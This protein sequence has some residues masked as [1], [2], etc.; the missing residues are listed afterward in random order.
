MTDASYWQFTKPCNECCKR[1]MEWELNKLVS[2]TGASTAVLKTHLEPLKNEL[3]TLLAGTKTADEDKL[4]E[5]K[6]LLDE[7]LDPSWKIFFEVHKIADKTA[8][9]NWKATKFSATRPTMTSRSE[10]ETVWDNGWIDPTTPAI[11]D[12]NI[13]KYETTVNTKTISTE[14]FNP[15][16]VSKAEL[17]KVYDLITAIENTTGTIEAK[18]RQKDIDALNNSKLPWGRKKDDVVYARTLKFSDLRDK[19]SVLTNARKAVDTKI[20]ERI[21]EA[22]DKDLFKP[23]NIQEEFNK[24]GNKKKYWT[25]TWKGCL[26]N[27]EENTIDFGNGIKG[28][29]IL[30][31][32]AFA[33]YF[34]ETVINSKINDAD[35]KTLLEG[36]TTKFTGEIEKQVW[37]DPAYNTKLKT[38]TVT[39][40]ALTY[41]LLQSTD[42]QGKLV[43]V[44]NKGM[45]AK[46]TPL[47]SRSLTWTFD[48]GKLTT[49]NFTADGNKALTGLGIDASKIAKLVLL[50]NSAS[51]DGRYGKEKTNLTGKTLEEITINITRLSA[52]TTEDGGATLVIPTFAYYTIEVELPK[53]ALNWTDVN[54]KF[55]DTNLV[56]AWKTAGFTIEKAKEWIDIGMDAKDDQEFVA[57]LV[58]VKKG[59]Y[60]NP[61]WVLDNVRGQDLINLKNN[62][63]ASTTKAPTGLDKDRQDI[64]K[65]IQAIIDKYKTAG[66]A[67]NFEKELDEWN[68]TGEG[69]HYHKGKTWKEDV[70]KLPEGKDA[71]KGKLDSID[72]SSLKYGVAEFFTVATL[73]STKTNDEKKAL[74]EEYFKIK[75]NQT[76]WNPIK[77]NDSAR[78]KYLKGSNIKAEL[79]TIGITV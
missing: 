62:F 65:E 68:T 42:E 3:D 14:N 45:V 11:A 49:N 27:T 10:A 75:F 64:E 41:P 8:Q 66:V 72:V 47:H 2:P 77:A 55:N 59:D 25:T 12:R 76:Q 73:G 50:F 56:T 21:T 29:E 6:A 61:K 17:D 7:A 23:L 40:P 60:A 57:W 79:G 36:Y 9:G 44:D 22:K 58:N 78:T 51:E 52:L 74:I 53:K 1:V 38:L 71:E 24:F 5:L 19:D 63:V 33:E 16:L 46:D 69:Q 20:L 43:F 48:V 4:K 13:A 15:L 70:K 67:T 30:L 32:R 18:F 28:V 31:T 34:L 39:I 54:A 35:K 37:N 26:A